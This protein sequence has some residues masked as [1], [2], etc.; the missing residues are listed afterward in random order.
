M[1]GSAPPSSPFG[2]PPQ[3]SY[4]DFDTSWP[5]ISRKSPS[6]RPG[7]LTNCVLPLSK[8]VH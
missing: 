7:R 1:C 3:K 4:L 6:V 2:R 5:L 8:F